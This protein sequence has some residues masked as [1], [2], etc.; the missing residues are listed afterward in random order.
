MTP[1]NAFQPRQSTTP[2]I[3]RETVAAVVR[4]S[5][6]LFSCLGILVCSNQPL[7]F[8]DRMNVSYCE[9]MSRGTAKTNRFPMTRKANASDQA[10]LAPSPQLSRPRYLNLLHSDLQ[11]THASAFLHQQLTRTGVEAEGP[12]LG[13][14]EHCSTTMTGRKS[15]Q[16]QSKSRTRIAGPTFVES[17]SALPLASV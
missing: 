7:S 13:G 8:T 6:R 17:R 15:P 1:C 14:Q 4:T 3:C 16:N 10:C 5:A 11:H 12:C 9:V 2:A